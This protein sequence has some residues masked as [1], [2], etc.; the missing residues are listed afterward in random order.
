M[1]QREERK[2]TNASEERV[3]GDGWGVDCMYTRLVSPF[4]SGRETYIRKGLL[5]L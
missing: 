2:D 5:L 3:N 4:P 1:T